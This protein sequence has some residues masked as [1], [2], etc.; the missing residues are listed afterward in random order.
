MTCKHLETK[1]WGRKL[2]AKK[3]ETSR[4]FRILQNEKLRSVNRSFTNVR[5][6][7]CRIEAHRIL[8]GKLKIT[9]LY[10]P[11]ILQEDN[12]FE[13]NKVR[14]YNRPSIVSIYGCDLSKTLKT[15]YTLLERNWSLL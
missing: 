3:G 7:Q 5:T 15:R 4:Q 8:L 9:A 13:I 10:Q 14:G 12:V 1:V 6:I 11:K 2:R